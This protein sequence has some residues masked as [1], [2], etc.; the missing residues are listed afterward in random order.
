MSSV[1]QM[2]SVMQSALAKRW[3][4]E[5]DQGL[6]ALHEE[7]SRLENEPAADLPDR[8]IVAAMLAMARVSQWNLKSADPRPAERPSASEAADII[9]GVEAAIQLLS[10]AAAQ[11]PSVPV[12]AEVQGPLHAQAAMLLTDLGRADGGTP[13]SGLI[14][15]ARDHMAQVPP[16]MMDQMPPVVRDIFLLQRIVADNGPPDADEAE[17]LAARFREVMETAGGDLSVAEAA[18]RQARQRNNPADIGTAISELNKAGIALPAGSPLRARMLISL[19]DMH[20][21]LAMHTGYPLALGDAVGAAIEALRVASEPREKKSAAQR[22][23]VAFSLMIVM[24]Q[25][26]GPLDQAEQLLRGTLADADP[27]D[28]PLRVV[29]TVGIAA[30]VGVRA[31][32]SADHNLRADAVRLIIDA[33]RLLPDAIP[34]SD[35]YGAAR[36]LYIWTTVHA[37]HDVCTDLAP[38]ALRVIDQLEE[39]LLNSP[40]LANHAASETRGAPAGDTVITTE[41]ETLRGARARLLAAADQPS[42][43]ESRGEPWPSPD[44]GEVRRLA[45]RGLDRSAAALDGTGPDGLPRRPLTATARPQPALLRD[46]MTDLHDALAAPARDLEVRRQIDEALGWCAAELYWADP[47]ERTAE[48]LRE[49]VVHLNRALASSQHEPPTTARADLLDVLARCQ[50]EVALHHSAADRERFQAEAKHSAR[51]AV[52]ELARCVLLTEDATQAL[53]VAAHANEIVARAVGWCLTDGEDRAAVEMGAA[54][55]E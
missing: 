19:A 27:G 41:L 24:G 51:A 25:C 10:A 36:T 46:A 13:D 14:A 30:A 44:P 2:T 16:E 48:T 15:R 8:A 40:Q 38:V 49:A 50:H 52:R 55:L 29:A 1:T 54:R 18:A 32:G 17:R 6:A 3:T 43:D 7:A 35:W 26:D 11:S 37:L 5:A 4:S 31:A 22:M 45:R 12:F 23:I 33:E 39:V 53:E 28:W 34:D 21:L 47:A 9:A 20:T 42:E